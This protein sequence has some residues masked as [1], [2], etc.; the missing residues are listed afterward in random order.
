MFKNLLQNL[1]SK[2]EI[3][4][5]VKSFVR[6]LRYIKG[7]LDILVENP[8]FNTSELKEIFEDLTK[9]YPDK[10]EKEKNLYIEVTNS[11]VEYINEVKRIQNIVDTYNE[12]EILKDP[13]KID[14]AFFE[15]F[16]IASKKIRNFNK[17]S[18]YFNEFLVS[19]NNLKR[20]YH[21][22]L[23]QY[24]FIPFFREMDSL[25]GK[26]YIDLYKKE[27]LK[28]SYLTCI[29]SIKRTKRNYYKLNEN[30]NIE[31]CINDNNK[32]YLSNEIRKPLFDDING[33]SLDL[34]QRISI[35]LNEKSNLVIAGAG[36]GK[37]LTICGKVKY[38]LE[39]KN[40]K[41]SDILL[42]SYSAKSSE[43]LSKKVLKINP[44]LKVSTFHALGLSILNSTSKYKQTVE[45]Q[46]DAIV[47]QYFNDV[48]KTKPELLEKVITFVAYY[49]SP[50]K[51]SKKYENTGDLFHDLKTND[52]TTFKSALVNI[53]DTGVGLRTIK[54]ENVKSFEE[55]AIANFYFIKGIKYTYEYP[56][57]ELTATEDKRQYTPDFYLE[58]YD[59]YHE[60]Y[61]VNEKEEA[62]QYSNEEALEYKRSM[63]WKRA[64]HALHE[65]RR[66]S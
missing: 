26:T 28:E 31:N 62:V 58:D 23:I 35:T 60:H 12:S 36:S 45:E 46:F 30:L 52:L 43:D 38:L 54:K 13:S 61:G 1:K 29:E 15:K 16:Q 55:M 63:I 64:I 9:K 18:T 25:D 50:N 3:R 59:I 33:Y 65:T 8:Q 20:D 34:E 22:I 56:Y 66:N 24:E 6:Q 2:F 41:P 48:L 11:I 17:V 57:C 37:T 5:N 39:E 21:D 27:E 32:K 19:Y 42:L 7:R 4:K 53:S 40:V 49:S 51:R 44:D 14:N 10:Y 47:E